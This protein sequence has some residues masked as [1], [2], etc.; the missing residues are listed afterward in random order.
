MSL[1]ISRHA[2][3]MAGFEGSAERLAPEGT[4]YDAAAADFPQ[5]VEA[6]ETLGA[7]RAKVIQLYRGWI[8]VHAA[9]HRHLFAAW[10]NLGAELGS[11]GDAAGA[12]QAYQAA[13]ALRPDFAAAATNYGLQ[14]ERAGDVNAAMA[15]WEGAT[16]TDQARTSL[17]N[18]RARLLERSGQLQQAERLLFTS[19]LT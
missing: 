1:S 17:I 13:L 10:F 7:D 9:G 19:L 11:A 15:A 12:M 16:Q 5:L 3:P 8:A 14:L 6:A 18:H 2:A 4:R